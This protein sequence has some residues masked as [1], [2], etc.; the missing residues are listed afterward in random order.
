MAGVLRT[1]L[2]GAC[3]LH[4][5]IRSSCPSSR[6]LAAHFL[7]GHFSFVFTLGGNGVSS[8][9]AYTEKYFRR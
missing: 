5:Y 4:M 9:I 3:A 2:F 1:S 8:L 7:Y 6:F